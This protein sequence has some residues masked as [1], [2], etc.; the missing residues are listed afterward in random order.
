MKLSL[1]SIKNE[2][3]N[4]RKIW[5]DVAVKNNWANKNKIDVQ[6]WFNESGEIVDSVS[7]LGITKDIY[8]LRDDDDNELKAV[9]DLKEVMGWFK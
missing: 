8:I 1:E 3:E 5:Q 9:Y 4:N 7:H 2:V 6:V